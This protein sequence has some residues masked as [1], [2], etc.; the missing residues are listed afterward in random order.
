MG[1]PIPNASPPIS[2]A[3][4]QGHLLRRYPNSRVVRGRERLVWS[5]GLTPTEYSATY[6]VL[7]DHQIGKS[8]LVYV[9]RPRLR[10]VDGQALPHVYPLNTLC[11]F[12][13]NREW[14]DSIPIAD[15]LVPWASEWLLFYELW[16][17]TGGEWL[18]EG[19]HP[20]PGPLDRR[21][22]RRSGRQNTSSLKRLTLALQLVYGVHTDLEKLLFNAKL[23]SNL[24]GPETLTRLHDLAGGRASGGF[25]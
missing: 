14:H 9:A 7:I 18:G 25:S 6:E 4:Q 12:L 10:L 13:G 3:A 11:L 16:L 24:P 17:A 2:L 22:R 1:S 19:E 15:T 5:G 21:A 23:G 20:L 8:P